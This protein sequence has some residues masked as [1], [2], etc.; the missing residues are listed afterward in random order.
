MSVEKIRFGF[1]VKNARKS[2]EKTA[3]DQQD[4]DVRV[5][6]VCCLDS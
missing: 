3:R 5:L 1:V 4:P 6:L 2:M